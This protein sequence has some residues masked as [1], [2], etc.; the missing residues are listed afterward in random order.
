MEAHPNR[1]PDETRTLQT[2]SLLTVATVAIAVALIYT[3]TLMVPFALSVLLAYLLAPL[4]DWLQDRA[5]L[6]RWLA[7]TA[8][9]LAILGVF[10]GL[11]ALISSSVAGLGDNASLYG[12]RLRSLTEKVGVWLDD[13]GIDLGQKDMVA[14]VKDLPLFDWLKRTAGGVLNFLSNF[15]LVLIFVIYLVAGRRPESTGQK[16]ELEA[17]IRAYL[18]TKITLSAITG[19]LTTVILLVLGV[20]LALVF[21]LMAFLLNFIPN[22]GSVIATLL[23]LP[24]VLMQFD[25]TAMIVL[26][27]VLPGAVQMVIGNVFEPKMLGKSVDLNPI[28]ILLALIFWGL[29][30]GIVGMLLA[31]PLTAVLKV[32]LERFEITRPVAR[33]MGSNQDDPPE[34]SQPGESPEPS[35]PSEASA[36]A[37][38]STPSS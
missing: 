22:V 18:F 10:V 37:G 27:I 1:V 17:K 28:T 34:P 30:W 31:T 35:E 2:L 32:Q 29:I 38:H 3:R 16:A 4:I 24:V 12:D 21:G 33:L 6:P 11:T 14:A 13:N 19:V 9:L 26:A 15:F 20:D 36:K 25:S 7:I 5:K 8:T 23:P